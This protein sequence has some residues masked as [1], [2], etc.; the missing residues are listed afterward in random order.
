MFLTQSDPALGSNNVRDVPAVKPHPPNPAQHSLQCLPLSPPNRA[1]VQ[2]RSY[3]VPKSVYVGQ[4]QFTLAQARLS[5]CS[6]LLTLIIIFD[7]I[8]PSIL[9]YFNS[10][11]VGLELVA[12]I[13]IVKM[14]PIF[15][16][17]KSCLPS[18][19]FVLLT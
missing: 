15:E 14:S 18:C 11:Q 3:P 12:Y 1:P 17:K 9:D 4:L 2:P 10:S 6:G 5:I 8:R 13:E 7:R 16:N 19:I